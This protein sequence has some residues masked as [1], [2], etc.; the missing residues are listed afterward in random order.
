MAIPSVR[1]L[2]AAVRT[3]LDAHPTL[4]VYTSIVE[5]AP[6]IDEGGVVRGYAVL[7]PGPGD[8]S[9]N[10]LAAT[11]GALLWTFQVTCAGGNDEYTAWVIDTVRGLLTGKTLAVAST[12]VGVMRPPFGFTPPTLTNLSVQ[13]PRISVPLQYQVLASA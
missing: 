5:P 3:I 9:P 7:H 10:N 4:T 6:P 8:D 11:P 12:N 1:L 2:T 13:P